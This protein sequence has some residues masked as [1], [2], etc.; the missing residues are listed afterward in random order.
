[1][2]INVDN[3]L[4]FGNYINQLRTTA[5]H[6]VGVMT[7][8]RHFIPL[9][10]PKLIYFGFNHSRLTYSIIVWGATFPSHPTP[11][12]SLQSRA[13]NLRSGA[14]RFQ[15]VQPLYTQHNSVSVKTY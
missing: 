10:I 4:L 2:A 15:T 3:L 6:T 1:M 14:S 7:K 13:I 5:S 8:I 11:L 12:K 9:R